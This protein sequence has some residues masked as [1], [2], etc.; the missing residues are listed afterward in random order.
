MNIDDYITGLRKEHGINF[1]F[2][3]GELKVRISGDAPAREVMDEVRSRKEDIISFFK[4][5]ERGNDQ[6]PISPAS[7]KAYYTLSSAQKRLYFI[8]TIDP[9]SIAYNLPRVVKLS[10]TLD[11]DR[12]SRAF[13]ALICRHDSLRTSFHIVDNEPV[14]RIGLPIPFDVVHDRGDASTVT[15]S[16]REFVRPFDLATAPL[17]RAGVVSFNNTEHVLMVDMHHIISDGIS[18]SL[19]EKELM[20]LYEG[21]VLDSLVWQYKDFAEWEQHNK[22]G[23]AAVAK[24][25]WL[26]E[27]AGEVPVLELPTDFSRPRVKSYHGGTVIFSADEAVTQRLKTIAEEQSTTLFTVLLAAYTILL[28]RLSNQQDVVVGTPVAG[29][30]NEAFDNTL[31]M[32]VNVLPLRNKPATTKSFRDFLAEVKTGTFAAFNHQIFQYETLINELKIHRQTSRN[33]LFDAMFVWHNYDVPV[34]DMPSLQLAPFDYQ[35]SIA[36]FDLLLSASETDRQ[37]SFT[38]E[39]ATEL[40]AE[41][42]IRRFTGFFL[43]IIHAIAHSIDIRLG[44]IPILPP[45]EKDLI[46]HSF[47]NTKRD[48]PRQSTIISLFEECVEVNPGNTAVIFGNESLTYRALDNRANQVACYLTAGHNLSPGDK[49]AVILERE[50]NLIPIIFGILKAGG[51]YVPIDPAFPSERIQTVI[52]D[53]DIH[54][55]LSRGTFLQ[56]LNNVHGEKI[57]LDLEMATIIAY[58]MQPLDHK[59]SGEDLAY[60]IYTSGSSG[61]PKGVMIEHHSLVNRLLWMQR[62][63]PLTAADVLVQKTPL[64]FD[65]S[66]WELFW[67]SI[68]GAALCLLK[69]GEEKDPRCI[70]DAILKQKI[71]VIHFVPS[72]LSAF[73]GSLF[74]DFKYETLQSLTRVFCS[75]EALTA[76]HVAAFGAKLYSTNGTALT[77]LYG[78]T[79]ATVDVSYYDCRFDTGEAGHPPI[80]KPIDNTQLYILDE[81]GGLS[82][83]GIPGELYIGGVGVA[84]GYLGNEQLTREKFIDDSIGHAG[85]LYRTGDQAKWL[86]DGNIMYLGRIDNQVK[87]RGY[88]IELG[89]IESHLLLYPGITEAAAAV[90]EKEGDKMLVAYYISTEVIPA[91][92]L[93][94]YLAIR[95]PAYMVP[96][97]FVPLQSLPLTANGKLNRKALPDA[98]VASVKVYQAPVT[99]KEQL[100]ARVW[101]QVLGV[102]GVGIT[103]NFFAIGGDSIKS[104]QIS[105][106]LRSHGYEVT[107]QSIFDTQTIRLLAGRLRP[108]SA[109]ADQG[110]VV[111][112]ARVSPV[113]QW[114]LNKPDDFRRRFVQTVLFSFPSRITLEEVTL[115]INRLQ[116]HHDALRMVFHERAGGWQQENKGV[117]Y[118]TLIEEKDLRGHP[119]PIEAMK[120]HREKLQS[121]IDLQRGPLMRLALYHVDEG[122]R[123]L[124]VVH[125]LVIDGVSWRIITE[126]LATLYE[127]VKNEVT[128]PL[129]SK[130]GAYLLWSAGW[131][132]YRRSSA[133]QEASR[134]WSAFYDVP[135][136]ALP[137]ERKSV[138]P[139]RVDRAICSLT[140]GETSQLLTDVL[141]PFGMRVDEVMLVALLVCLK[142]CYG[143][144][145]LVVDLEGHGRDASCPGIDVSRT[146]GWFTAIYPVRLSTGGS[147]LA[148]TMR[149]VKEHLRRVPNHGIDYLLWKQVEGRAA[150]QSEILFNYLGQFDA[151][152][153]DKPFA[154]AEEGEAIAGEHH[155]LGDYAW[156]FAG[157][158]RG[159]CLTLELLYHSGYYIKE[160][161]ELLMAVYHDSLR[162]VMNYCLNCEGRILSPVDLTYR[163]IS[164]TQLDELQQRYEV[165]DIYP[166]S[167]MQ[168]GMLF[169]SLVEGYEGSYAGQTTCRITGILDVPLL[170][171]CMKMLTTRHAIL[172]TIFLH[173]GY[174][175]NLQVVVRQRPVDFCFL[176]I[177]DECT[178]SARQ[179]VVQAYRD[180]E[181]SHSFNLSTDVLMRLLVLQTGHDEY[182][183]IWSHHHVLM[184]G[185]CVSILIREFLQLYNSQK[186]GSVH[187]LE[188][189]V[190]YA[191]YIAWLEKWDKEAAALYWKEYLGQ[192]NQRATFPVAQPSSQRPHTP[193]HMGTC[194]AELN[195][196]DTEKMNRFSREHGI[197]VNIILQ[198][199]WGVLLSKYNNTRD[200]VFGTVVSGRPPEVYGVENMI[201]LFVNTVPVRIRYEAEERVIDLLKRL[202]SEAMESSQHYYYPLSEIQTQG[203]LGGHLLDHIIAFENF[204]VAEQMG[205]MQPQMPFQISDGDYAVQTHYPLSLTIRPA[206]RI[207]IRFDYNENVYAAPLMAQVLSYFCNLIM[208]LVE[209]IFEPVRNILFRRAEEQRQLMASLARPLDAGHDLSCVQHVL[210]RSFM[211]HAD[212]VAVEY[213]GRSYTYKQVG[214]LASSIAVVLCKMNMPAGERVGIH[215]ADRY[216]LIATMVGILNARLAFV[217]LDT[218]QPRQRIASMISQANI[219]VVVADDTENISLLNTD[220][221]TVLELPDILEKKEGASVVAPAYALHD[222]VYVYFTSGSTGQPKGV[223]GLNHGLAHFIDW[224]ITTFQV[225]HT[226]R[227]SQ[228]TNPG[229]DV[230][231]RD[232]LVP[233]CAG[234]TICVP[235]EAGVLTMGEETADWL[236]DQQITLVHCVPAVFKVI[237]KRSLPANAYNHLKF[238]LLAGEKILPA[239]LQPWYTRYDDQV[240]LVNIY[241]P[242]ETT[243]AKAFYRIRPEDSFGTFIPLRPMNGAQVLILDDDLLVVPPGAVGQIYI[244]TPFRTAGY[245]DELLNN[246]AFIVN[247]YSNHHHDL[248]YKTGDLGRQHPS[249]FE[250]LG[251]RDGQIKIRGIRVELD[252][253]RKNI[254]L[255]P[256]IA[257]AVVLAAEDAEGEVVLSAYYE[258]PSEEPGLDRFL[259]DRLPAYMVP[260]FFM[261]MHALP[262]LPN[263]KVDRKSLPMPGRAPVQQVTLPANDMEN[264]LVGIWADILL[265]DAACIDTDRSFFDLGGHSIKVFSLINKIQQAFAVKLKLRDLFEHVTIGSM[266][267]LIENLASEAEGVI[268]YVGEQSSYSAS[269]AQERMYYQHLLHKENT[270][271]NISVPL[272]INGTPD[273]QRLSA[274]FQRLTDRHE[275]LRT[276]FELTAGGL[277]QKVQK[278]YAFRLETISSDGYPSVVEA[279]N[280]FVRPFRLTEDTLM[281]VALYTDATGAFLFFDI[282]HIVADGASLDIIIKDFK[283]IYLGETLP[284]VKI[285]YVDYAA[286]LRAGGPQIE[287]QRKYWLGI[288]SGELPRIELPLRQPRREADRKQVAYSEVV[289]DGQIYQDVKKLALVHKTSD[290]VVLLSAYYLL[291]AK[292]SGSD[293]LIVGTD[294]LG[295]SHSELDGLVGTFVNVLPLRCSIGPDDTYLDFLRNVKMCVIDA[296]D[297]QDVQFDEI[298][299]LVD[300]SALDD[301]RHPVFD[302]Y[303]SFANAV[304][305]KREMDE[306]DFLPM[307]IRKQI[308]AEYELAV[309]IKDSN[310]SF[311]ATFIYASELYDAPTVD[312]LSAYF[313]KIVG[314]A[315]SQPA[316][317]MD[318]ITLEAVLEDYE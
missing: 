163:D 178:T 40:F 171:T 58:A 273:A 212:R 313:K 174:S 20:M 37:L 280:A 311:V 93:R 127:Q 309:T 182:E 254:L 179:E 101:E 54:I 83:I 80:G 29:R 53:A 26:N 147:G 104:I 92:S 177:A 87:I 122:D 307:A 69:P 201:G 155:A 281:R 75:G 59:P 81:A 114:L 231:M 30:L 112:L 192:Y 271:F 161:M 185:W 71:T 305:G 160:N 228:L 36:K 63:Y 291:L 96:A 95:L 48:Y 129:P 204:P 41:N 239:I 168:E 234:A 261:H 116:M 258:G 235:P 221:L 242:T 109:V 196:E 84:R 4:S 55:I 250:V 262:L 60:V 107:V 308:K 70:A 126:D 236:A 49:V 25:F 56:T 195:K 295:R 72:M 194:K 135:V 111:G 293:D 285:R 259:K 176:N 76:E 198:T 203:D 294:V 138:E 251:R 229:F 144:T 312:I 31:G 118:H 8:Y 225:D 304:D 150:S 315:A 217:V 233:L 3:N 61:R 188:D 34:Y 245:L 282:H 146:V 131:H 143:L 2:A 207:S 277:I 88:R 278:D 263:G 265:I 249:G 216:H 6:P 145:S 175:R 209:K 39:Y 113:Q 165:E 47:N 199:A 24:A 7:V 121:T 167:P 272:K 52:K 38:F 298:I 18:Q 314:I 290:F 91:D 190:P 154:I 286:W 139:G 9:S 200:V 132:A 224:E 28:A 86:S 232:V 300:Q 302:Y 94:Q 211:E 267:K 162:D 125:H 181:K 106:R 68:T 268:P 317:K 243:L 119:L 16:I 237:T 44:D 51:V 297:N 269:P 223:V 252:D 318:D 316:I 45:E 247:P 35:Q 103:D 222:P 202:Q 64:V 46:L 208:D 14:Q 270:D 166:L 306:L 264:T 169:H 214:E 152:L 136:S 140:T 189:V 173:E 134:Y 141:V 142:K 288:L 296:A 241:G 98:N 105:S 197:T 279:F 133:Y 12:L 219:D 79:E 164:I 276:S 108:I 187:T 65:V 299:S 310:N 159:G 287:E 85:R 183:L 99:A 5:V 124:I 128:H 193:Y 74:D 256:G 43:R 215:C 11:I 184:D 248:I 78:P 186:T 100:L 13:Y 274:A 66:I 102:T 213:E 21:G 170:E 292:M 226:F 22:A 137:R 115:I 157:M 240:Q 246:D 73:L 148:E 50:F 180:K 57:D 244:R 97:W 33:P 275:M 266:A 257:D 151:D 283:K 255:Y 156:H 191:R 230:F 19:F 220:G 23:Y 301:F 82:P 117:P 10:G 32:F 90:K 123:L 227:F 253:V 130:T 303:F 284:P 27:F 260:S 15:D 1:T 238:V 158:V 289:V 62:S 67:W 120:E 17:C 89:E 149:L 77:N 172:R 205:A 153:Q 218:G 210:Q 206:E 42:T 110:S